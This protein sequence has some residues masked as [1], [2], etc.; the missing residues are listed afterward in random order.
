MKI[1][2]ITLGCKTNQY[3]TEAMRSGLIRDGHQ[4]VDDSTACDA[5]VV[6]ACAVT[7]AACA[8]ARQVVRRFVK[9]QPKPF[10][11]VVGCYPQTDPEA[12]ARIEGVDLVLGTTEKYRI[13]EYLE[14]RAEG[15]LVSEILSSSA[16]P[17]AGIEGHRGHTRAFLK[18]QEGCDQECAYCIV[19]RARGRSRNRDLFSIVGEASRLVERGYIEAVLTGTQLG[20]ELL[21]QVLEGLESVEGL[22]RIRVSSLD[23]NEVSERLLRQMAASGKVTRHLHIAIQSGDDRILTRMRRPYGAGNIQ[24]TL[25]MIAGILG[26]EIGLGTDLLVGFPGEDE[27]AFENTYRLVE[28]GPFTYLHLFPFSPRPGTEAF[29][30]KPVVPQAKVKERLVA[31]RALGSAKKKAFQERFIGR[32]LEVLVEHI[33]DRQTQQLTGLTG[34]Y[35]RVFFDGGEELKGKLV[36]VEITSNNPLGLRGNLA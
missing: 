23:P 11:A 1:R 35:L 33:G 29:N 25:E 31:L 30:M 10:L 22:K 16:Y 4:V 6:N 26:E 13:G 36:N 27:A 2:L 15:T 19:P 24:R 9:N 18:I 14:K 7:A 32:I 34:H 5:V 8:Q 3:D 28:R 21:H 17:E 12:L 20:E